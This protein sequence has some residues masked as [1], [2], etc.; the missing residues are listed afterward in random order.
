[1]SVSKDNKS[2]SAAAVPDDEFE[3]FPH[4][5]KTW[6]ERVSSARANASDWS[7]EESALGI[8]KEWEDSWDDDDVEDDF[9]KQLKAELSK[10]ENDSAMKQ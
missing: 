4:E 8:K 1:M 6:V 5:G 3:D 10:Q 7:N 2:A 9:S